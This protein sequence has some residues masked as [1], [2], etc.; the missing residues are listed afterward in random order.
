MSK[1]CVKCG[2]EMDNSAK[3]C[4]DCGAPVAGAGT[5][6]NRDIAMCVILSIVTCGIYGLYWFIC[7]TDD[8]NKV[9]DMEKTA[10]GGM[11]LLYTIIT[12]G[13]YSI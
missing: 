10:T 8:S 13:I 11:S 9:S 1:F 4:P 2:K 5:I 12:C 6:V 3:A 7:L